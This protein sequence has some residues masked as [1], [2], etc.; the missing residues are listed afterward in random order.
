VATLRI[1]GFRAGEVV[2]ALFCTSKGQL[3]SSYPADRLVTGYFGEESV[4]AETTQPHGLQDSDADATAFNSEGLLH[5]KTQ[6]ADAAHSSLATTH[7]D[8][9]CEQVVVRRCKDEAIEIHCHG[10]NAAVARIESLLVAA[11]CQNVSWQAWAADER[12]DSIAAD[13]WIALAQARTERTASILLDQYHGALRRAIDDIQA[14]IDRGSVINRGSVA[15]HGSVDNRGNRDFAKQQIDVLCQRIP[16]GLHL[17]QPWNVVLGGSVNVGK[18]SLI[19]AL[20]G[21]G[22]SIVHATPGTTR[23]AVTVTTAIDG[24]PVHLC[25]TAGLHASR[26]PIEQA[27]IELA[28]QRLSEADLVVLV[29]D[30]SQPWSDADQTLWEQW[31]NAL[32][33]FNKSDLPH[34]P[35][36]SHSS[37][38]RHLFAHCSPSD[39]CSPSDSR[40]VGL[41][42][43][44][45]QGVGLD[46]LLSAMA[47]RLVPHPPTPGDAVP[48][49]LAQ[50]ELIRRIAAALGMH[51][52]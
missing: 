20:V 29:F 28:K 24:W 6:G 18:S 5:E 26:D 22:R 25:D 39:L 13:A 37:D 27:G 10:G 46:V 40:P 7:S 12:Q 34:S 50:A 45:K 36:T 33:V 31:P 32:V 42:V 15:E 4:I 14:A 1:E 30:I 52:S 38:P 41:M 9:T 51:A 49:N 11:G 8:S 23:D 47:N 43:S 17:V 16:L 3:L 21:Y 44:A 2:D 48:F 19:N 35:T